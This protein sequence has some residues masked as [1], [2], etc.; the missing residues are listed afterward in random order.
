MEKRIATRKSKRADLQGLRGVAIL[1]VFVMHL[2]PKT[3][4]FGFVG[5]DIFFVLSGYLMSR[6]L[7]HK[8]TTAVSTMDFYGRRG[9]LVNDLLWVCTF[10]SNLQPVF[11]RLGYFEQLTKFR[12]FVHTWSLGVELQYYLIAPVITK[13]AS[14]C[15]NNIRLMFLLF[16]AV[17]SAA[18]QLYTPPN[19]SYGFP[20]SRI[21]QFL[22]GAIVNELTTLPSTTTHEY[23]LLSNQ[24][25]RKQDADKRD[26]Y[27]LEHMSNLQKQ[28]AP[29]TDQE[30][31]YAIE[32]NMRQLSGD[33]HL[34]CGKD[35]TQLHSKF[36]G[37]QWRCV[38]SGNGTA[39]IILV[40]NSFARRA[41]PLIHNILK[42]RYRKFRLLAASGCAPLLNW[43]S[44]FSGAVREMVQRE[45]PDIVLDI[46]YDIVG[47]VEDIETDMTY[48]QYQSNINFISN[49][50]R[51]IVIDMPYFKHNF[52]IG[53]EL[54]RK[55]RHGLSLGDEFVVTWKQYIK[56]TRSTRIFRSSINCTKCIFNDIAEGLFQSGSFLTYDPV[57]FLA[58]ISDTH[59][60]TPVGLEL[61]RPLYTRILEKLLQL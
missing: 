50:T 21:W 33:V 47:P 61:L 12:F 25:H 2:K 45:R 38:A 15:T 9:Q 24:D 59:H 13:I 60:L 22:C 37:I 8:G 28:K 58:R 56:Q 49:F 23:E 40:G 1:L 4:R 29:G 31:D 54:A 20:V 10:T 52:L 30:I 27:T 39:N 14:Y 18:F 53:A 55:L 44:S 26:H 11:Q 17:P 35:D 43:C 51:F 5:V 46:H 34:P 41:Y 19:I 7:K 48:N 6:M 16:L 36:K 42:G 57:T 32:W 3:Y